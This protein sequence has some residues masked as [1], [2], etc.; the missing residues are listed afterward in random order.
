MS[1][2]TTRT[3]SSGMPNASA[4]IVA[5]VVSVPLMSTEPVT[6]VMPPSES[7]R[8]AAAAGSRPPGHQPMPTPTAS[9]SGRSPRACQSG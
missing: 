1:A 7:S 5:K 4:A 9:F 3:R 6:I 2:A 8:Q